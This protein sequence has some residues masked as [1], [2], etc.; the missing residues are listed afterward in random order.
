VQRGS[1]EHPG[2]VRGARMALQ[3]TAVQQGQECPPVDLPIDTAGSS[4]VTSPRWAWA[5][6]DEARLTRNL[7]A[8]FEI[9]VRWRLEEIA[10]EY[11]TDA[12]EPHDELADP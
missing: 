5:S 2:D 8:Y 11:G 4:P 1:A 6:P 10:A 7:I 9:L 3:P 12:K